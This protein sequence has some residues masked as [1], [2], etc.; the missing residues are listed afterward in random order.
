MGRTNTRST[1]IRN[2]ETRNTQ[3]VT[4]I[5]IVGIARNKYRT[6]NQPKIMDETEGEAGI[7]QAFAMETLFDMEGLI[8][9]IHSR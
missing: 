4:D 8:D 9:T 3:N 7:F 2:N 6:L 5:Q 1:Y